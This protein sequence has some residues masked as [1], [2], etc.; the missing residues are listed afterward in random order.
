MKNL[1]VLLVGI[2]DYP[3]PNPVLKGC[4]KDINQIED[5]LKEFCAKDYQLHIKRLENSTA[6][7]AN[8]KSSFRD[9]LGAAGP[10]D[11]AW[12]HFS[13]HG[14]EEKTAPEFLTLEPNGK[15]QTLICSDSGIGGVPNLADKELAVLLNEV[16]TKN[17]SQP[18]HI[19]VSLDCCHSGSGTR[20][21]GDDIQWTSR[22]APS[23]GATRTLDSYADGYYSRLKNI[24]VPVS[25]HV[26]IS[27]CKSVQTAGDM[28]QGGAFTTGLIKTL[29]AAKGNLS[30]TD[31][32]LRSRSSVQTIRDNQTPQFDTVNN[33]DPY[34]RF[35]EGSPTGEKDLYEVVK[36]DGKWFVKCGAIHG[37]PTQPSAPLAFDIY[38]PPPEKVL[39]GAA[40]IKAVGA[41]MSSIDID[42]DSGGVVNFFKKLTNN[43]EEEFRAALR[44]LPTPPELASL[45]GDASLIASIQNDPKLKAKNVAWA[46]PGEKV[47]LEVQLTPDAIT[48]MDLDKGRKAF[49]TDGS[50]KD[51]ISTVIDAL[52]KIVVWRRFIE[53][54][55]KNQA[56]QV[57][58]MVR[59]ELH[60]IDEAGGIK[61]HGPGAVRIFASSQ[62][63]SNRIPA[64]RPVIHVQ[65][66]QQNL[67][68][69]LF[70]VAFD[71]SISCPGGE[72][73]YRPYEHEDKSNI[74][75]PLWKK[76]LGWG[77]A[78]GNAEDTCHF[79]LIVTTEP[80]DHQQFLQSGLGTHRDI[81]GEPTPEKVFDDWAAYDI[82]VTMVRQ[83]N[84][85]SSSTDVSLADGNIKIKAHP[86]M[87]AS[88]SIGHAE[89]N[90]RSTGPMN[91]FARLQQNNPMQM[92]DFSPSRSAQ[93]QNV[94]EINNIRLA[95]EDALENQPLEI[96][97]KHTPDEN[98]F[99]LPVAFDGKHFRVIGDAVSDS[100]G[101]HI[102]IREI[103]DA[104]QTDA[105]GMGERSL[106]KALKMTLFKV[107]LAKPVNELCWV[108]K[109]ADGDLVLQRENLGLKVGKAKKTLLILHGMAGDG[110]SMLKA[111]RDNMPS[112]SIDG[113]DLILVYNYESLNTPLD[114]TAAQLGK[115]LADYGYGSNDDRKMT[116]ISHS[117][118]GLIA[119]WM[120]EKG[121]AK[122]YVEHCVLVGTPNNGS[123]FGR[124]DAYVKWSQTVLDMAINFMPTIVPFS[125]V[126]L[127][128]FKTASDLGG[129]IA[130]IDPNSE[131]INKLNSTSDPGIRYTVISGDATGV[132]YEGSGYDG[133]I[134]K[135]KSR[136][137]KWMN[138]DE[139]NDLFAPVKSLQCKELWEGR[140]AANKVLEPV[141]NHHFGYFVTPGGTRS[142]NTVWKQLSEEIK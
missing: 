19:L 107:A 128:F 70:F 1:Y 53:L 16:A 56:S 133:F 75:I 39:K 89:A 85:I 97:L 82:A 71:Y 10:A 106:F 101:T 23:S 102:R 87:T 8:I 61:K 111:I 36:K 72:I 91:A 130:Q 121:G 6:T 67:Y 135:A 32:F 60:E 18:P 99:V 11:I 15:D 122:S 68:C 88:V 30:Y 132:D 136:L 42:L 117:L 24:E 50:T 21:V 13:G 124:V 86:A 47:S 138:S 139:P 90:T 26:V 77:P 137:G 100:E 64:F 104:P 5:Y 27:A 76:T 25:K 114:V 110:L 2:N 55:N 31:L 51:H 125:G 65:N 44:H 62:S 7:Y 142:S 126:L 45:T 93:T 14:S 9:H 49:V 40:T 80:L 34:V 119:R 141:A 28:P 17:K 81:L 116:I 140:N 37:L 105:S 112:G 57:K 48:V 22:A 46:Q 58:D 92:V 109:A 103:P 127:K 20:S 38:S 94:I 63:L 115:T 54:H 59:Y 98:E 4:I 120:I 83:D 113:Y 95:S 66:I 69:Y 43:E 74:E 108:E 35:L 29:R 131:F 134:E 73:V 129:S 78:A 84:A 96:T 3:A 33:F 118:G 52:D 79:K 41:Q 12:F 123:M